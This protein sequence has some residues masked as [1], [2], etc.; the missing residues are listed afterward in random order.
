[1]RNLPLVVRTRLVC[2][3]RYEARIKLLGSHTRS[4][5]QSSCWSSSG[6]TALDHQ[7]ATCRQAGFVLGPGVRKGRVDV[8]GRSERFAMRLRGFI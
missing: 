5:T 3:V 2:V 7:A 1:M 6:P 8:Y 4:K